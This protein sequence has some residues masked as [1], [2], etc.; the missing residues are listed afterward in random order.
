MVGALIMTYKQLKG[1]VEKLQK[2]YG[3]VLARERRQVRH[4][5]WYEQFTQLGFAVYYPNSVDINSQIP[6]ELFQLLL[7]FKVF[8]KE[9]AN[10]IETYNYKNYRVLWDQYRDTFIVK[11]L[12]DSAF[13]DAIDA[14]LKQ[15]KKLGIT[16]KRV[17]HIIEYISINT[18][19]VYATYLKNKYN[20]VTNNR[21]F[22]IFIGILTAILENQLGLYKRDK[23][24]VE[25]KDI[26]RDI[27]SRVLLCTLDYDP[28]NKNQ[29]PFNNETAVQFMIN[30]LYPLVGRDR[31]DKI[32]IIGATEYKGIDIKVLRKLYGLYSVIESNAHK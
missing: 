4:L 6:S 9:Y 27:D 5:I 11:K 10:T 8:V 15:A 23:T 12:L 20:S 26:V 18:K 7:R 17:E 31:I 21:E 32:D 22:D 28:K 19:T 30:K 2:Q 14:G 24:I 16:N 3:R 25:L 1:E 13:G 29:W